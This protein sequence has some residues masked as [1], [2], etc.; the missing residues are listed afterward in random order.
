[1]PTSTSSLNEAWA[2]SAEVN[3]KQVSKR[4]PPFS[5]RL[6]GQQRKR[7][8]QEARGKPLGVYVRS[9]IFEEDGILRSRKARPIEDA[10]S[11]SRILVMLGQS[12]ISS[13]LSKLAGAANSG[14]LPVTPEIC[15]ALTQ[16]CKDVGEVRALLL[17][18]LGARK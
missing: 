1:M 6:T 2:R 18:A 16:A 13:D 17:K 9:L 4:P 5:I 11:L 3:S 12:G 7:L 15:Q 14:A 10:E 8:E